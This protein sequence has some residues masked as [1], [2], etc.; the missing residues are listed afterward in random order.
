MKHPRAWWKER[1]KVFLAECAHLVETEVGGNALEAIFLCGSFA[2]GEES[3]VLETDGPVL[4]SDVDLVVVVKS[5]EAQLEWYPRRA[6][7]GSRCE[8]SFEEVRFSGHVDIGVMLPDDLRR[9]PARPGVYDMKKR[10]RVLSGNARILDLIPDYRADDITA[11]EALILIENRVISV[12]G[13]C[14]ARSQVRDD[15]PYRLLYGT[16][17]AYTDI[18]TAALSIA[19]CYV[20]GYV[21]RRD[22]VRRKIEGEKHEIL[23]HLVSP[24]M[25]SK[26]DHW[27]GYKVD[28]SLRER[29]TSGDACVG[30]Q[31]WTEAA[32]DV[33][34]FW[35]QGMTFW[36]NPRGDLSRPLPVGALVGKSRDYRSWRANAIR[37]RSFLSRFPAPLGIL[38]AVS[39]GRDSWGASPLDIIREEGLRLLD[40][41]LTRGLEAPVRG[42]RF[43][44]PYHGGPWKQVSAEL[45]SLWSELVFGRKGA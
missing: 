23:S 18:A 31:I 38:R 5:L 37:W 39:L 1:S 41:G 2:T 11:R 24:D 12:L 28:P 34:W 17:R 7:L 29:G 33:L 44:F 8:G 42:G 45:F 19:G 20:P 36:R 21:A 16:A 40:K 25:L 26:I 4:L 6:E 43:G 32:R 13:C 9:L 35:R 15:E 14:P 22:L 10:G 3:I 30:E 27:T